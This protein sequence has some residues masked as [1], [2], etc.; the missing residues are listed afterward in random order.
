MSKVI[1][2][3]PAVSIEKDSPDYYPPLCPQ[4]PIITARCVHFPLY[5]RNITARCVRNPDFRS[6]Y[7]YY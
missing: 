6:Q 2:L 1:L 3:P 7:E 4:E 5:V